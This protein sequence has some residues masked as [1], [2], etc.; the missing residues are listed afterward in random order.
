VRLAVDVPGEV[1]GRPAQLEQRL[2]EVAAL[3]GVHHHRVVVDPLADEPGDLLGAHHLLEHRA[4]GAR[5]HQSVGRV[6]LEPQPSVAR[7]RLGDVD[8]QGVRDGVPAE[9]EQ[10]VDD[11][12]RIV[13]GGSRV[14]Q[15]QRRQPVGV[16]VLG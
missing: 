6:L 10:G 4:V 14:P 2:L 8:E 16:D 1:L 12:L 11:L 9:R 13:S 15:R 5:Q 7:H 3:G